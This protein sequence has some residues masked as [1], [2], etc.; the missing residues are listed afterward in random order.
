MSRVVNMNDNQPFA[1]ALKKVLEDEPGKSINA[2]SR[3]RLHRAEDVHLPD[4]VQEQHQQE[5][6]NELQSMFDFSDSRAG[7][8]W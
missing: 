1:V 5:A 4:A 6:K 8:C 3:T 2:G 7:K